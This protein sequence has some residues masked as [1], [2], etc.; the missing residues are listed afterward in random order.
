MSI[1][2][3][4]RSEL[5]RCN[6]GEPD[7]TV[8]L[9]ILDAFFDTW[10]SGGAVFVAANV[11]ARLVKG[12]PLTPL[13]GDDS[14]WMEVGPNVW[15]NIRCGTVFRDETGRCYDIDVDGRP[16]IVFPYYPPTSPVRSPVIEVETP[17]AE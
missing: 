9:Q 13:T 15:Q 17:D 1:R 10:D 3:A 11:L 8:M 16:T 6:F 14:E 4:A 12:L 7:S 5:A 2:D